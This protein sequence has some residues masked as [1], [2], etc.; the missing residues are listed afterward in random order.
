MTDLKNQKKNIIDI[1][2]K[3]ERD[4]EKDTALL[5]KKSGKHTISFLMLSEKGNLLDPTFVINV[6]EKI[7]ELNEV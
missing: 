3:L 1:E 7:G 5:L 2:L 4:L 6:A